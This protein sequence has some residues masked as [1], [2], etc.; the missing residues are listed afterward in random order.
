MSAFVTEVI[1]KCVSLYIVLVPPIGICV[2]FLL[3]SYYNTV[4]VLV[5]YIWILYYNCNTSHSAQMRRQK[6]K[7]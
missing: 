2:G 3:V 1:Y 6:S 4:D 5:V 7:T